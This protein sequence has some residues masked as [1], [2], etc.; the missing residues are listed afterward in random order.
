MIQFQ[1]QCYRSSHTHT[2]SSI[3]S[4]FEL[5]ATFAA[6]CYFSF[7]LFK[8]FIHNMKN[9][10]DYRAA[11]ESFALG[12]QPQH[13]IRC[14]LISENSIATSIEKFQEANALHDVHR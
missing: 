9:E 14:Q 4:Y 7:T 11:V 6:A 8:L 13:L 3:Y 5:R 12:Y 2:H 10:Y 1:P